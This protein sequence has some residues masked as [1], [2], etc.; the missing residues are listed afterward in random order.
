MKRLIAILILRP[1]VARN[2]RLRAAGRLPDEWYWADELMCKWGM[3]DL[4][5][6]GKV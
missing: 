3:F 1:L 4:T 5:P 2:Y 6:M